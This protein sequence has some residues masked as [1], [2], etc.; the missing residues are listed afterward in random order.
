MSKKN[1]QPITERIIKKEA[2]YSVK[3]FNPTAEDIAEILDIDENASVFH[4]G[5]VLIFKNGE[6]DRVAE[7]GVVEGAPLPSLRSPPR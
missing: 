7:G 4:D 5:D 2:I 3:G 6:L 1:W